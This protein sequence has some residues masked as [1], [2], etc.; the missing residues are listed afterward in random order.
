MSA[1][2]PPPKKPLPPGKPPSATAEPMQRR[3]FGTS[4]AKSVSAHK[5]V[6][7]GPGGVGKTEL[8]SL[9]AAFGVRPLFID[10]EDGSKFIDVDRVEPFVERWEEMRSIL[11]GSALDD[12][13]A[14]VIDSFTKAEE[15]ALAWTL[16]NVKHEKGHQVDGIE[17]Y[18]FGKGFSH[19]YET[20]L[21]L[22]G[23]LDAVARRGK[24]VIG[25]AHDCVANVPNPAG[26]DWIRYEPRLQSPTGGK[27]ST[28]LRVKEWCDHM[29]FVG[30]DTFVK[31][32]KAQGGGTRTIY[33]VEMPTHMAKSRLLSDPIPYERGNAELWN[34]LF[35]KG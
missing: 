3:S 17:G 6:I 1:A 28:R 22:L 30:F 9:T 23:D 32:G 2:M 4:R 11:Q 12:F 29:L 20:F 7:Y 13:N 10:L 15:L 33:P 26:E 31:D 14:V 16:Q 5:I 34:Q 19:V 24:H 35:K 21:Q 25:I 27:S 18:G 8:A